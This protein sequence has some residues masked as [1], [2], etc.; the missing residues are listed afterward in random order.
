MVY[1]DR[2]YKAQAA[3]DLL[4]PVQCSFIA[5]SEFDLKFRT[6]HG[7]STNVTLM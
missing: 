3:Y 5:G 4:L 1:F 2:R 6:V 7:E